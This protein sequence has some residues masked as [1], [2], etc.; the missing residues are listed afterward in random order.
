MKMK[1]H[2]SPDPLAGWSGTSVHIM[3]FLTLLVI[4]G[5]L[6]LSP[7][8]TSCVCVL[9]GPLRAAGTSPASCAGSAWTS[10]IP[11]TTDWTSS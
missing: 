7:V 1:Q 4:L 2:H 6:W 10:R 5:S 3:F 11:S 9:P 8:S